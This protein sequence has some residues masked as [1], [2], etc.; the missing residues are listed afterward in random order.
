MGSKGG[1]IGRM[2]LPPGAAGEGGVNS[3]TKTQGGP[4]KVV[5]FFHH[6]ISLEPFRIKRKGFYQNV[7]SVS[8]CLER[9]QR[10]GVLKNVQLL[11]LRVC[12]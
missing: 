4:Q 2:Q 7:P 6:T 9:L 12:L 5:Q 10:Y 1:R 11:G 3:F 8:V